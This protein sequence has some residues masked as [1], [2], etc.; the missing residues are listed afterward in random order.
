MRMNNIN[1]RYLMKQL[2]ESLL[3][4]LLEHYLIHIVQ[5]LII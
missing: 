1:K 2:N 5:C 3:T 4:D